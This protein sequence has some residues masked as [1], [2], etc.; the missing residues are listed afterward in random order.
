M[1]QADDLKV[2]AFF[3]DLS[4]TELEKLAAIMKEKD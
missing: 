1:I 2:I 4:Q 3:K